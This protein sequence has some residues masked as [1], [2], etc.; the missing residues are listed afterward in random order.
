[1]VVEAL[2]LGDAWIGAVTL[3]LR[4]ALKSGRAF[5]WR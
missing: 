2:I 1:M 3:S 5:H 4:L